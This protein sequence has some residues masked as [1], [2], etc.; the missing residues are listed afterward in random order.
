MRLGHHSSPHGPLLDPS[1]GSPAH[2]EPPLGPPAPLGWDGDGHL[3]SHVII[4]VF[5][6]ALGRERIISLAQDYDNQIQERK[7]KLSGKDK[8]Q[9]NLDTC[10][11]WSQ[12]L[13][14][15][16]PKWTQS[17]PSPPPSPEGLLL[18]LSQPSPL[19]GG[20][21]S[22]SHSSEHPRIRAG[23]RSMSHLPLRSPGRW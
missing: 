10:C 7:H 12:E 20:P 3:N 14:L 13:R 23:Q 2:L 11:H 16:H 1:S 15:T 9:F 21:C 4:R 5:V 22:L 19:F 18:L 17:A 8:L 6:F